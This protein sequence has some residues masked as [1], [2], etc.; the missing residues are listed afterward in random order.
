MAATFGQFPAIFRFAAALF[1]PTH[2]SAGRP[3]RLG[4]KIPIVFFP[5]KIDT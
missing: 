3:L 1:S 4:W 5:D 2:L